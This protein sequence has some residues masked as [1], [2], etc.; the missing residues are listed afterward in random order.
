MESDFSTNDGQGQWRHTTE[1]IEERTSPRQ[2]L[3]I[4]IGAA[5]AVILV[6]TAALVFFVAH[7]A[8]NSPQAVANRYCT[9]LLHQDYTSAYG[10]FTAQFRAQVPAAAYIT[11]SQVIDMQRGNVTR[12]ATANMRQR[13]TTATLQATMTR[14]K[15]GAEAE[16]LPLAQ[17]SGTWDLARA[18]DATLLPLAT[19]YQFCQALQEPHFGSAYQW[20]SPQFVQSEGSPNTFLSDATSSVQLTG[21][22]QGCH[23]QEVRLS[24]NAQQATI[25]FGIDFVRFTNM[26]AQIS[27]VANG[28]GW[29]VDQMNFT[30]AG[31]S[32]PFPL[33]I[34][35]VENVIGIL[36]T[37]CALAPPNQVC[38]IIQLLP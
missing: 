1:V 14:Q 26:P 15:A 31:F 21:A 16:T 10:M 33:P 28:A 7:N 34:A 12:C 9:A 20:L 13:N 36:K 25:K 27:V 37:I 35:K 11:S 18:P 22:V 32:L 3:P 38:T 19:V 8:N 17:D 24:G 5:L 6:A 30:A 2:K 23:L 29:Q 4:F